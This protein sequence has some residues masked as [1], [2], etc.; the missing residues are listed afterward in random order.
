MYHKKSQ[1]ERFRVKLVK[2]ARTIP[3]D[4]YKIAIN[5]NKLEYKHTLNEYIWSATN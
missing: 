1:I 4:K 3:I 2:I 5:N